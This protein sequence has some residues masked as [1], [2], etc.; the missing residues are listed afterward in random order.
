VLVEEGRLL[1]GTRTR[2]RLRHIPYDVHLIRIDWHVNEASAALRELLPKANQNLDS[3]DHTFEA[4]G[5]RLRLDA[6]RSGSD[7]VRI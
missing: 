4:F 3:T 6:K 7:P 5:K 2:R 1:H